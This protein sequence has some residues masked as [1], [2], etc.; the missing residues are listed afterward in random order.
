[1]LELPGSPSFF[2]SAC[3][4]WTFL[5]YREM[6]K[7]FTELCLSNNEFKHVSLRHF[8]KLDESLFSSG[9]IHS[10]L[11]SSNFCNSMKY[12]LKYLLPLPRRLF[13]P[14]RFFN[15]FYLSA[16]LSKNYWKHFHETRWKKGTRAKKEPIQ[17]WQRYMLYW[18]LQSC[19]SCLSE[20]KFLSA[21]SR[22]FEI[23]SQNIWPVL[24]WFL[25][26]SIYMKT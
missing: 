4:I 8:S 2:S 17:P 25:S 14:V 19:F 12:L 10:S 15:L 21:I 6:H 13:N 9:D 16:G 26:M 5:K 7:S 20:K 18:V 1:M 22:S 3:S 23:K 11:S 24:L